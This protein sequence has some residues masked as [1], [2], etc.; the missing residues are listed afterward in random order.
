[1]AG[2]S[3]AQVLVAASLVAGSVTEASSANGNGAQGIVDVEVHETSSV[4]TIIGLDANGAQVAKYEINLGSYIMDPFYTEGIEGL[5]V[6]GRRITIDV[7]NVHSYFETVDYPDI[8]AMLPRGELGAFVG[9]P[10]VAP[11]LASWGI[12]YR[13]GNVLGAGQV[14]FMDEPPPTGMIADTGYSDGKTCNGIT[15]G[16]VA[17]KQDTQEILLNQNGIRVTSTHTDGACGANAPGGGC[18]LCGGNQGPAPYVGL[19]TA[20]VLLGD[21]PNQTYFAQFCTNPNNLAPFFGPFFEVKACRINGVDLEHCPSGGQYTSCGCTALPNIKCMPC[22]DFL[23]GILGHYNYIPPVLGEIDATTQNPISSEASEALKHIEGFDWTASN[24]LQFSY[25]E[26]PREKNVY[27]TADVQCAEGL[28]CSLKEFG[29]GKC[30]PIEEPEAV[31]R[32]SSMLKS[33]R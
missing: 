2:V 14:A 33:D 31:E 23:D 6:D 12:R 8:V 28:F 10:R 3:F 30:S 20:S 9:D 17:G 5:L 22:H 27:C 24:F 4:K 18:Q 26:S 7:G 11:V 1:M 32:L 19:T 16:Y 21:L 25:G 15:C 13:A 29:W